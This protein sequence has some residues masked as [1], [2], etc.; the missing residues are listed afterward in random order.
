MTLKDVRDHATTMWMTQ[1]N[2]NKQNSFMLFTMP[3]DSLT[4][5]A[6]AIIEN[7]KADYYIMGQPDG[8]CLFKAITAKA[9]VNTRATSTVIPWNL[10]S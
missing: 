7:M 2:Q 5:N 4:P 1:N 3:K 10:S 6:L 9:H 8:S